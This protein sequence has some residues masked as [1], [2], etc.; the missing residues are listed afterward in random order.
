MLHHAP[1]GHGGGARDDRTVTHTQLTLC[2]VSL[3]V[4]P[5]QTHSAAVGRV[6]ASI[7]F[8]R[9]PVANVFFGISDTIKVT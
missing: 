8:V 4:S 1:Q 9:K 7:S 3:P 5:G 2:L 6:P